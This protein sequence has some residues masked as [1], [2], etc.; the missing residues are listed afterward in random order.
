[1]KTLRH[2]SFLLSFALFFCLSV[3]GQNVGIGTPTPSEKLEVSG[4]MYTNEGGVRFPDG[5]LQTTAAQ[6]GNEVAASEVKAVG[7]LRING[8]SGPLDTLGLVGTFPVYKAYQDIRFNIGYD[9]GKIELVT[10]F[11]S[12][13]VEIMQRVATSTVVSFVTLDLAEIDSMGTPMIYQQ[14]GLG[15][16]QI[17]ISDFALSHKSGNEFSHLIHITFESRYVG[18]QEQIGGNCFCWDSQSNI[19]ASCSDCFN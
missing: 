8:I 7:F 16:A 3:N 15:S 14:I 4:I 1:M 10:E 5:T 9:F 19:I 18:W 2:L 11:G 6:S 13:A 17:T 12:S